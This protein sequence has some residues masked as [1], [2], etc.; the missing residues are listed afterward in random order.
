VASRF[1]NKTVTYRYRRIRIGPKYS[2]LSDFKPLILDPGGKIKYTKA[3]ALLTNR[4]T[5]SSAEDFALMLRSLPNV[6]Q[7]GDTTF[8]GVGTNPQ[9]KDLP[10]GWKYRISMDMNCDN[11]KKPIKNGIA[12][13][14]PIQI[15][16]VESNQ[17]IDK[18]LEEAVRRINKITA[19]N[20]VGN[21]KTSD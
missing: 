5:F 2:D 16:E 3:V 6:I 1:T 18:I 4:H 12:P 10:N 13:Q 8:G 14:I 11:N 20:R 19:S 15:S 21:R 7:I 17:G 9:Y